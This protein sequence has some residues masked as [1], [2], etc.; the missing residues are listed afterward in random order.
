MTSLHWA[1]ALTAEQVACQTVAALGSGV[2]HD[3][4]N[5]GYGRGQGHKKSHL[6]T[7]PPIQAASL[8][9]HCTF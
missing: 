8:N 5:W 9:R 2:L 1:E 4:I 7:W 3:Q 6:G